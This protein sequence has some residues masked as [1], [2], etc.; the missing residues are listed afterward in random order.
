M[1][2]GIRP[3]C[4]TL[5]LGQDPMTLYGIDS[6]EMSID[7][8]ATA[9]GKR[10]AEEFV[11]PAGKKHKPEDWQLPAT[12]GSLSFQMQNQFRA[13]PSIL[14]YASMDSAALAGKQEDFFLEEYGTNDAMVLDQRAHNPTDPIPHECSSF[15]PCLV[16]MNRNSA[17]VL[18]KDE[19]R[20]LFER[21]ASQFR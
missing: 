9:T 20:V 14:S 18:M 2:E 8:P 5:D 12:E 15:L 16:C 17:A 13:G 4:V 11:L 3:A 7:P 19:R 6:I 1:M 21:Y 10:P